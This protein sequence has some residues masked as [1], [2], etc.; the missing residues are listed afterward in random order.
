MSDDSAPWA[1]PLPPYGVPLGHL[2]PDS[3]VLEG[4]ASGSPIP[5][6]SALFHIEGDVLMLDGDVPAAL[7]L[8]PGTYLAR[9]DLPEGLEAHAAPVASALSEAGMD[10][11]DEETLLAAPVA[12]QVLGLRLSSW[13]LWGNDIEAA[14]ASLRAAAVG[15]QWL[16]QGSDGTLPW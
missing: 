5:A 3:V 8:C 15:E 2:A 13:N 12:M 11:L 14:F 6:H 10:L 4:F 7:R 9:T 1:A 16:P